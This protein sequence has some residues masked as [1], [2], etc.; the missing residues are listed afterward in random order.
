MARCRLPISCDALQD[1]V[2]HP[3]PD[4]LAM[5]VAADTQ[6]GASRGLARDWRYRDQEPLAVAAADVAGIRTFSSV[7]MLR[8][9]RSGR[10]HR[11]LPPEVRPFT[12]KQIALVPNFAAQAVIAIENTRLLNELR[13]RT[14]DLTESLEQQTATSE[15][16]KRHLQLAGRSCSPCSTPCW[17][18]PPPVRGNRR[19]SGAMTA[20]VLRA[21]R[22]TTTPR[23]P[24]PHITCARRSSPAA[25]GRFDWRRSSG[26]RSTSPISPPSRDTP[27]IV[28]N[29]AGARAFWPFRCSRKSELVGAIAI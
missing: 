13:Q 14:D 28:L 10:R 29:S 4:T 1:A 16:L 20:K 15:V 23:R 24:L 25:R 17:P 8:D 6:A 18:T 9:E 27:P 21:A 7:P 19:R 11:H 26:G 2:I 3:R 12:D 22:H 5:R